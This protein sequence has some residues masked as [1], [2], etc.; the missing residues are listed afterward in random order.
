LHY[1]DV[2]GEELITRLRA[3]NANLPPGAFGILEAKL[4]AW[5]TWFQTPTPDEFA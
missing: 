1:L 4:R 2:L 5:M 3:R